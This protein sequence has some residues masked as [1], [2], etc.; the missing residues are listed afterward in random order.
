MNLDNIINET[1]NDFDLGCKVRNMSVDNNTD[2]QEKLL[3]VTADFD[4]YKKRVIKEKDDLVFKTKSSMI[5]AILDIDS[6]IA[7]AAKHSNDDGI[8]LI[9]SKLDKFLISN[10]I[11]VI[12]TE[13]Y[14]HDIHEAVGISKIEH[15]KSDVITDVVS[16]GYKMGNKIIRYPKVILNQ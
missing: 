10:G 5:E 7:L 14:D 6:D 1:P 12:Q 16:K 3:R 8:K 15:L 4:N 9:I 2:Y 11:E 13:T